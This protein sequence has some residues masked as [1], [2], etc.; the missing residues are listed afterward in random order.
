M[1]LRETWKANDNDKETCIWCYRY[2]SL[3]VIEDPCNGRKRWEE[4]NVESAAL[5]NDAFRSSGQTK[6]FGPRPRIATGQA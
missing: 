1:K 2:A 4:A 3:C 6:Q 5:I